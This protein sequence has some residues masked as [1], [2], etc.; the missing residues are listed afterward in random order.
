M[1]VRPLPPGRGA[2]VK[3]RD[4]DDQIADEHN[5][6]QNLQD[7]EAREAKQDRE[8]KNVARKPGQIARGTVEDETESSA[9]D[10]EVQGKLQHDVEPDKAKRKSAKEAQKNEKQRRDKDKDGGEKGSESDD[11]EPPQSTMTVAE[12][13]QDR[14]VNLARERGFQQTPSIGEVVIG[15]MQMPTGPS[16]AEIL[17]EARTRMGPQLDEPEMRPP[18]FLSAFEGMKDIYLKIKGRTSPRTKELLDG[19]DLED[20]VRMIGEL[21]ENED[22]MRSAEGRL[23]GPIYA[24]LKDEPGPLLLGLN[25]PRLAEPWRLFIDGWDIW[26]PKVESQLEDAEETGVELFWE[27]EAEDEDGEEFEIM[28]S[29][30]FKNDEVRLHTKFADDEDDVTFDGQTFFRLTR[31]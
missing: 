10:A 22:L 6:P 28:Q 13:A 16:F 21:H 15:K 30:V 20:L 3:V 24:H 8:D 1:A 31:R 29:L 5:K 19:V 26:V 4:V 7:A 23:R 11:D 25:D 18:P 9:D 12:L 17:P 27:G 14:R 2:S